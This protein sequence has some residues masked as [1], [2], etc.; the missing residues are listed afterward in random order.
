MYVYIYIC[1]YIYIYVRVH[2]Y[3]YMCVCVYALSMY[4]SYIF[5]GG[6][7]PEAVEG[8]SSEAC[9]DPLTAQETM[10]GRQGH[11]APGFRV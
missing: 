2:I 8:T 6:V 9:L 5:L 11:L 1:I 10:A 7:T 4:V 3:I